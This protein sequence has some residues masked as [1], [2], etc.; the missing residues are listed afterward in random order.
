M[1]WLWVATLL[2]SIPQVYNQIIREDKCQLFVTSFDW[3]VNGRFTFG[4][5][6][7]TQTQMSLGRCISSCVHFRA[8]DGKRQCKSINYNPTLRQ[9]QVFKKELSM[10][11][12]DIL[13]KETSSLFEVEEGWFHYSPN[14]NTTMVRVYFKVRKCRLQKIFANQAFREISRLL[15]EFS[16]AN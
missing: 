11:I 3:V 13:F 6:T 9:C 8:E 4:K 14:P 1:E 16:F 2:A 10:A 15:M 12:P 7:F 5:M